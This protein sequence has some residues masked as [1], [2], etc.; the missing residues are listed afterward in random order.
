MLAGNFTSRSD[1]RPPGSST[2]LNLLAVLFTL[3]FAACGATTTPDAGAPEIENGKDC[4][5]AGAV[6]K[7]G[8][9]ATQGC[10]SIDG[11]QRQICASSVCTSTACTGG[12]NCVVFPTT[13]LCIP[14]CP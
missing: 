14:A 4:S 7:S 6:C 1:W 13:S 3:S 5:G 12:D 10:T 2:S 9:C 8:L 11:G